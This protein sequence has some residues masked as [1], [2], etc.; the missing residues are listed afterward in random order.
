MPGHRTDFPSTICIA[1]WAAALLAEFP[2]TGQVRA[3][4]ATTTLQV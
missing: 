4:D 1:L 3:D 2:G